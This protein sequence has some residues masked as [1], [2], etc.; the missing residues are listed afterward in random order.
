MSS[1]ELKVCEKGYSLHSGVQP[2]RQAKAKQILYTLSTNITEF[3]KCM[4]NR[5]PAISTK[6]WAEKNRYI[7]NSVTFKNCKLIRLSSIV[8]L[9][10][11]LSLFYVP[12][13]DISIPTKPKMNKD[14]S[15]KIMF[16]LN[17][18]QHVAPRIPLVNST[19]F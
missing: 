12:T 18:R 4:T 6:R 14:A 9:H 15:G 8:L 2:K 16:F 19:S 3:Q 7:L 11:C 13:K 5:F 1:L 10:L 17:I